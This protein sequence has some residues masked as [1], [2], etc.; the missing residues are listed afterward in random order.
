MVCSDLWSFLLD[1]LWYFAMLNIVTFAGTR[2]QY[3][4]LHQIAKLYLYAP[5]SGMFSC[6][7][8]MTD[9]AAAILTNQ[10][11]NGR[12][13]FFFLTTLRTWFCPFPFIK[14]QGNRQGLNW[15]YHNFLVEIRFVWLA[16]EPTRSF[17]YEQSVFK[18]ASTWLF[19]SSFLALKISEIFPMGHRS[20]NFYS[21]IWASKFLQYTFSCFL[22][23]D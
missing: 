9:G 22:S 23:E 15:G 20:L 3:R 16:L 1:F 13:M 11:R 5:S 12:Y 7:L 6:P 18:P 8:A 17:F 10:V 21:F 2:C 14:S 4:R 19:F